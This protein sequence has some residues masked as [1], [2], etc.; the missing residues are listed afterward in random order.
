[1]NNE[2]VLHTG[3]Y[4]T[5]YT[6]IQVVR[7]STPQEWENYG[8]ILRRVDEAK[9][10]AIGDWL[11]DGKTHYGDGL[12]DRASSILGIDKNQLMNFKSISDRFRI[13]QRCEICSWGQHR[14]LSSLKKITTN[15]SGKMSW[16]DEHDID[17][18]QEFLS[19]A[20]KENLS[21][22]DLRQAVQ[23]YIVDQ[24]NKFRLANEPKKYHVIYADPPW[25]VESIVMD[26][27]QS[28]IEDKYPTMTIEEISALPVRN[29][30]AEVCSLFLWTTHA[31]L[32]DALHIIDRWGFKYFCII[33]WDKGGGWTQNG[34]HKRTE[35]LL[36][37]YKGKMNVDQFG[38][39]IPTIIY[40]D[41]KEH[42]R[43]PDSIRKLIEDKIVGNK[44]E[45]FARAKF[46]GWDAWGNEV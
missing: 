7:Q 13:S 45:M 43:K 23:Q 44:I 21:V 14:E 34:F 33:T 26:K 9:Q 36:Y 28:P 2:L 41:K 19:Q 22:R 29:I 24:E 1:M 18:A 30:S 27:W 35:L 6:G 42:S 5:T 11:V 32:H 4:R 8:E 38:E 46:D 10:W 15:E 3:P 25:P 17:K 40:E 20:A 37:S 39:S 16:S 31:F 12:Y